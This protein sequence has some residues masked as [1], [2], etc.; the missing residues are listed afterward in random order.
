MRLAP[1]Q[2]QGAAAARKT[3]FNFARRTHTYDL[4]FLLNKAVGQRETCLRRR[5]KV[6]ALWLR[7]MK[8][9]ELWKEISFMQ[10][11][12]RAAAGA[13]THTNTLGCLR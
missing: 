10:V 8:F 5:E 7:V 2:G 4:F 11:T 9:E 12:A 3:S 6:N 13:R 1:A